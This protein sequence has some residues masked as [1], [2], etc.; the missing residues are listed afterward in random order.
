MTKCFCKDLTASAM[1]AGLLLVA[2]AVNAAGFALYEQAASG[3]GNAM[4]GAGA[5]AEDASTIFFNPAGLTRLDGNHIILGVGVID[6]SL[7]FQNSGSLNPGPIAAPPAPSVGA[8]GG[9]AG[10]TAFIPNMYMSF[11]LSNDMKVGLGIN[12]PFGLSTEYDSD[13]VG[14][15]QAVR[16]ELKTINVNP[17]IAFRVSNIVSLGAGIDYQTI[18]A[19]LSR[20]VVLAPNTEGTQTFDSSNSSA[21][22]W[23]A[24]VLFE[25]NPMTR[26]GVSYRSSIEQTLTGDVAIAAPTGATLLSF[27]ASA[28]LKLPDSA[29]VSIV[30]DPNSRWE[31]LGDVTWTHWSVVNE[32][33][34]INTLNSS[35]PETLHLN[36][37]DA[38]RLS[39]GA[40]YKVNSRWTL[41]SGVAWD[42]SPV[43][44]ATRTANLPDSDRYWLAVGIKYRASARVAFDLGYAHLVFQSAPINQDLGDPTTRGTLVGSYDN[45]VDILAAHVTWTIN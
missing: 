20:K 6:P 13:W 16:S 10:A 33:R 44:N 1:G 7:K 14:R 23:N 30:L 19:Q 15:F 8:N 2:N 31:V 36:F 34:L 32:I 17:A 45:A 22:G 12:S 24:G 38:W 21:W 18:N 9:N 28:S 27:P 25:V 3:I 11:S 35:N 42:Q 41:K 39:L 5:I 4:A 29:S 37:H 43:T 26:L 40:N